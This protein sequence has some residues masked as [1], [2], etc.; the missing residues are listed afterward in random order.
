MGFIILLAGVIVG[1]W[2]IAD[3]APKGKGAWKGFIGVMLLIMGAALIL[4]LIMVGLM[5][6]F[7]L[8]VC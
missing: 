8:L 3:S 5:F 4:I 2:H 7:R 1:I 6:L